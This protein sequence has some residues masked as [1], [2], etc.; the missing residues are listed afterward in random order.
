[1]EKEETLDEPTNVIDLEV[2]MYKATGGDMSK[3]TEHPR[4]LAALSYCRKNGIDP[5]RIGIQELM[6]IRNSPEWQNAEEE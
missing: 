1:M 4:L 2:Y 3:I 5:S 6:E